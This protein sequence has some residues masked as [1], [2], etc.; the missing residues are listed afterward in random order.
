[1]L[2]V[3]VLTVGCFEGKIVTT[4]L[5]DAEQNPKQLMHGVFYALPRTIVKVDV[6]IVKTEM[7]MGVYSQ[8]AHCFF[9][10]EHKV[11]KVKAGTTFEI[12]TDNVKFDKLAIA[13]PK[14]I[15]VIR[16]KGDSMWETRSLEMSL[17]ESGVFVKGAAEST[18]ESLDILTSTIKDVVGIAAKTLTPAA[19][20]SNK[21]LDRK[22]ADEFKK[23]LTSVQAKCY[24]EV[25]DRVQEAEENLGLDQTRLE[26]DL[27]RSGAPESPKPNPRTRRRSPER[28]NNKLPKDGGAAA[29]DE[30][31]SKP[32]GMQGEAVNNAETN[33]AQLERHQEQVNE[34]RRHKEAKLRE[35]LAALQEELRKHQLTNEQASQR[36]KNL[37]QWFGHFDTDD[38]FKQANAIYDRIVE[39]EEKRDN[40]LGGSGFGNPLPSETFNK[41][42]AELDATIK[43]YKGKY[44]LGTKTKTP[45]VLS[46]KMNPKPPAS[47]KELFK[48]S[49]T[50]GICWLEEKQQG[51]VVN[52]DFKLERDPERQGDP[53]PCE[54]ARMVKLYIDFGDNGEGGT[55]DGQTTMS[56]EIASLTWDETGQRGFYYRI[57][58]RGVARLIIEAKTR[59]ESRQVTS[60]TEL[61]RETLSIA[62]FGR[63]VS[64]PASTGGRRTKYT[65]ELFESSGGLKNFIMGSDAL[66]KQSNLKDITDTAS[67]IVET[68]TAR[69][70]AR[71]KANLPP[72]ELTELE[73]K[74]KILEE[75]KKIQDLEKQLGT[76]GSGPNP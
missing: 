10:H 67:T 1:L 15:Y 70:E 41:M 9:P 61:G 53:D 11:E 35:E 46:F 13:D 6:P 75:K 39:L 50:G 49:E 27:K 21:V 16:T 2:L 26:G 31:S 17:T 73:R 44:F 59:V 32:L 18:N 72:D 55:T 52:G 58:G 64:L 29:A 37:E 33:D 76:E 12:D 56:S 3:S 66:V 43:A 69:K 47:S 36:Q 24:E 48:F 34:Q 20:L 71:R 74:R 68:E 14:E 5:K 4:K 30:P 23:Q 8:Y 40:L 62:Q 60:E 54:D 57:P 51:V 38:D 65:L 19:N 28:N 45:T 63:T 42:L 22:Q 7:K 25:L